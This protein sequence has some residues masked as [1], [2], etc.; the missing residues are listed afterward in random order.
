MAKRK[1]MQNS[2]REKVSSY[3]DTKQKHATKIQKF[4]MY[5]NIP[6]TS[7]PGD[8]KIPCFTWALVFGSNSKKS[9]L[10]QNLVTFWRHKIQKK[11]FF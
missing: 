5:P 10:L 3:L 4:S 7:T 9:F 6:N 2:L 11:Y 8:E 1:S